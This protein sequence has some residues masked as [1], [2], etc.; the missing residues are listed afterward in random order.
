MVERLTL[1]KPDD[2]HLHVRD[3]E[4]L[5]R[6]VPDSARRFTRAIIMPN[7]SPPIIT[8]ELARQYRNRILAAVPEDLRF[9]P[10]MTL[11][12]TEET[13]PS[14]IVK[15]KVSGFV[16]AV[17]WYPSGATTKAPSSCA[18]AFRVRPG[19]RQARHRGSVERKN[20]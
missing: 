17:K 8:T 9:E 3:G 4:L 7:L 16:H 13:A 11:F 10:L 14:E 2:W 6:V 1:T 19:W 18:I 5:R 12:L 15:A 20:R